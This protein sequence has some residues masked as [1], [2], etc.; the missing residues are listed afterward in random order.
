MP[1]IITELIRSFNDFTCKSKQFYFYL[2][3]S[4]TITD[5]SG[6][7]NFQSD[8]FHFELEYSLTHGAL[9][10]MRLKQGHVFDVG[11]LQLLVHPVVCHKDAGQ[12]LLSVSSLSHVKRNHMFG[13][14]EGRDWNMPVQRLKLTIVL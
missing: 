8:A 2:I 6:A 7:N 4:P 5:C 3:N 9:Q 10:S 12:L 1:C 13:I 11:Q 14:C